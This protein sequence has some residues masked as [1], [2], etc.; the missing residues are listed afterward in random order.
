MYVFDHVFDGSA[1]AECS[2]AQVYDRLMKPLINRAFEGYD[3]TFLAIGQSG[4]GKTYTVGFDQNVREIDVDMH[5]CR[6]FIVFFIVCNRCILSRM[7]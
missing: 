3:C 5:F 1:T 6:V 2:Q 7:E 4:S